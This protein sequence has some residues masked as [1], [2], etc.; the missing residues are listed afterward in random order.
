MLLIAKNSGAHQRRLAQ[1]DGRAVILNRRDLLLR[2]EIAHM[3]RDVP[4]QTA[5]VFVRGD[6]VVVTAPRLVK[7]Q[8]QELPLTPTEFDLLLLLLQASGEVLSR[9]HLFKCLWPAEAATGARLVDQHIRRLRQKLRDGAILVETVWG[10]GYR[11]TRVPNPAST[12][13][14][15]IS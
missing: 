4:A 12:T 13:T 3:F 1:D 10:Y 7:W 15:A 5:Q 8:G 14:P 9:K 2:L 6:L 11:M